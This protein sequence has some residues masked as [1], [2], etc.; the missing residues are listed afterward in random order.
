MAVAHHALEAR[1][2][3]GPDSWCVIS[4]VLVQII[5]RITAMRRA[6]LMPE[7]MHDRTGFH[8]PCFTVI[9]PG[10]YGYG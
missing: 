10:S 3:V 1:V 5:A 8:L 7:L 9:P 6:K 4:R 2:A